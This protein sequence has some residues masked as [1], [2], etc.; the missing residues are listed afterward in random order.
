MAILDPPRIIARASLVFDELLKSEVWRAALDK[1]KV[2]AAPLYVTSID[3]HAP[4]L[5][6]ARP[7][8]PNYYIVSVER[9]GGIS[10]RFAHHAETGDLLEA[11]G[12]RRAGARLPPYIDPPRMAESPTG[13]PEAVWMPCRESTTRFLPFWRLQIE[14]R[15]IYVRADG[16]TFDELTTTGRG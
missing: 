4:P 7:K 5:T 16:V 2:A 6:A 10:A 8:L 12:V 14:G 13:S 11:E 15:T 9:E 1:A 3:P